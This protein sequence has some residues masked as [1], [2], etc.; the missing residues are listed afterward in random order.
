MCNGAATGAVGARAKVGHIGQ[1]NVEG[2][3]L[4]NGGG[5]ELHAGVRVRLEGERR[6]TYVHGNGNNNPSAESCTS[7]H[8][9]PEV[10]NNRPAVTYRS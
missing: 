10:E 9:E 3:A 8:A 6:W 5:L 4:G 2:K 7:S 1:A